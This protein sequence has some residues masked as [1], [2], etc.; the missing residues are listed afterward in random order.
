VPPRTITGYLDLV[1]DVGLVA[2]IP[3]WTPNLANREIGRPKTFVIDS[4]IAMWLARLTPAQLT[5][6]ERGEAFGALLEAF[7]AAELLRQRTWSARRFDVFHYRERDGDEVDVVVEFDDGTVIGIEVK[8]AVS[9]TA[10]QFKGLARL[11]DRLGAR[12]IAGIV[13]NTGT[14][15]YRYADRLYGAP[16]SALWEFV[17]AARVVG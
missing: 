13:L 3:P 6:L 9:F 10:R 7:V 12:F 8:A 4:A 17:P 1:H 11:R 16:I 14:S 15:G 2:S 5:Q